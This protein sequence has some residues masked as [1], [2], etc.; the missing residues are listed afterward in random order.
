MRQSWYETALKNL[1]DGERLQFYEM[2][3]EFEFYGKEPDRNLMSAGVAILFDVAKEAL[4]QDVERALKLSVRNKRNG[5][6]GG[7]PK[8]NNNELQNNQNPDKPN[9][10]QQNPVGFFGL[11]NTS[12]NTITNTNTV[13]LSKAEVFEEKEKYDIAFYFFANGVVKAVEEMER[14]WNYY[15]AR[16]WEVSKG[17]P[18]RDRLALAHSWNCNDITTD[19]VDIRKSYVSLLSAIGCADLV[20]LSAFISMNYKEIETDKVVVTLKFKERCCIEI[21]ETKYI[22]RLISYFQDMTKQSG[23]KYTLKYDIRN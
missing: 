10:T 15:A 11:P 21:M 12:T 4:T 14:F 18:I 17:V 13:T 8:S 16:G 22:E 2:C 6:L 7:R 23:K 3:F 19:Y 5:L 1:R 20:L 9:E